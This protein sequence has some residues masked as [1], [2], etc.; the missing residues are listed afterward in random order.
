M[1]A[2]AEELRAAIDGKTVEAITGEWRVSV[3]S[4]QPPVAGSTKRV[5]DLRLVG[6]AEFNLR[7]EIAGEALLH[8]PPNR[9][10]RSWLLQKLSDYFAHNPGIQSGD[11]RTICVMHS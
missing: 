7:L 8:L 2:T 10:L 9:D 11:Q 5:L 6:A 3:L 4:P 1:A